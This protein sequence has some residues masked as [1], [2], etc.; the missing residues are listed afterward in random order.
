MTQWDVNGIY[1]LVNVY[2]TMERSTMLQLGKYLVFFWTSCETLWNNRFW[3]IPH[4]QK[5]PNSY[6]WFYIPLSEF[7]FNICICI[8]DMFIYVHHSYSI[9]VSPKWLCMFIHQIV[10]MMTMPNY[11]NI[12]HIQ[13]YLIDYSS[14]TI[15]TKNKSSRVGSRIP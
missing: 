10:Q 8:Y 14:F 7:I 1:P 12:R 4:L 15:S 2:K 13:S 9:N 5:H 6:C 11:T 3:N